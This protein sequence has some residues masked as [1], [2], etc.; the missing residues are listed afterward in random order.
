MVWLL[1][2]FVCRFFSWV[3]SVVSMNLNKLALIL[4]K[5]V[6]WPSSR[7]A[8]KNAE[9][10]GFTWH[11]PNRRNRSIGWAGFVRLATPG[12]S[13]LHAHL[14]WTPAFVQLVFFTGKGKCRPLIVNMNSFWIGN[15]IFCFFGGWWGFGIFF[16]FWWVTRI[17]NNSWILTRRKT[18]L[19]QSTYFV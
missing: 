11:S 18:S 7:D 8:K 12:Y 6:K 2:L 4:A 5:N 3:L 14:L 17:W 19:K 16:F 15:S 9:I 1:W 10:V 13:L